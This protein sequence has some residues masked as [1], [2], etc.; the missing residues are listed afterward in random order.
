MKTWQ[1]MARLIAYRPWLYLADA[2]L[3]ALI[4]LSPL[5]P[6]WLVHEFFSALTNGAQAQFDVWTVVALVIATAVGRIV[7]MLVGAWV[8]IPHRF[9]MSSL[10]RR[11]LLAHLLQRPGARAL[12]DT[13][14]EALNHFRDDALQAEDAISWTLD[15]IGMA[16]FGVG[17]LIA[18][19]NIDLNITFWVFAPLAAV[20][21]I[22]TIAS[23]HLERFRKASRAATGHV[24][25]ALGEMFNAVQAVQ[26]AGAEARVIHHFRGLGETRRKL[27]LR[28]RV[29][30]QGLD[31]VFANTVN[32]GTGLILLLAAQAMQAQTFSVGDFAL[33]VY[34]LNFVTQFTQFVG[35]FSAHYTQTGV[36]FDRMVQLMQDAQPEQ[37]VA[38]HPLHL[39]GPLQPH[40]PL[41]ELPA[42]S[43]VEPF[44]VLEARHLTWH[45]AETARGIT[46]VSL[47]ITAGQF[48]VITGRIGA[49]KTTLL[50]VLLGLLPKTAGEIWWNGALVTDPANFLI[51]P[52]VAYT[53][54]VPRLFSAP[55]RDN[56]LLGWPA[57]AADLAAACHAAVLVPDLA[58]MPQGLDTVI[59]TKGTR[60]SGGQIQRVAVARMWVRAPALLVLDDVSSA[61]DVNTE[62]QLWTQLT[63]LRQAD[64]A[65]TPPTCLVVSHRKP[66]LRHADNVI[67]LKEGRIAAAGPLPELLATSPDMRELW[68]GE[69]QD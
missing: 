36:S 37:L 44:K 8:D 6:G 68:E 62:Q 21:A 52:R 5:V 55:L 29:L 1:F 48:V 32:L 45:Y 30:T 22:T 58:T 47:R 69:L 39:Q 34:Y 41:P 13:A 31:S 40:D 27:M 61:L 18:L 43:T 49:G 3:W 9:S 64:G 15:I 10:L 7:M 67:V 4:H 51:P 46:D 57:S 59:G 63:A 24:T 16:L 53:P 65:G 38:H 2:V 19:A 14:G 17:A 12:P 60:L 11:N 20:M 50:R 23:D 54:Q 42:P 66:A 26:V 56:L 25:G 33:F 35:R 28:D